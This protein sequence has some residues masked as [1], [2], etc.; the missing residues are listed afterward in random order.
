MQAFPRTV[1][2]TAEPYEAEVQPR[3]VG[4][5]ACAVKQMRCRKTIGPD[6]IPSEF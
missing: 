3:M 2:L 1:Y 6:K 4:E 5:V